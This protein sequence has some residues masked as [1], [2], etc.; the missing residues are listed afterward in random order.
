[1]PTDSRLLEVARHKVVMA[2]KSA[3]I[4]LK[5]TFAR[6]GKSLRRRAGGYAHAKQYKRLR[7]V[8]KRQRT[9]L[10]IVLREVQRKLET[11]T[12]ESPFRVHRLTRFQGRARQIL[13][14]Y[15]LVESLRDL[16]SAP[17][18]GGIGEVTP[19]QPLLFGGKSST[20]V[21]HRQGV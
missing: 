7:R 18:V 9:V 21:T 6:E 16:M 1:F 20:A 14:Q 15:Q 17:G 4:A 8:L 2:A 13:K 5:Q 19:R 3:G 12:T 10:G 11:A